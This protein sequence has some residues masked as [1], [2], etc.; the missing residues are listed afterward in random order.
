MSVVAKREH[1][2][3]FNKQN[4][5][6]VLCVRFDCFHRLLSAKCSFEFFKSKNCFLND[7]MMLILWSKNSDR[8]LLHKYCLKSKE[9]TLKMKEIF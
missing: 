9:V 1:F 7:V 5:Q 3:G 8:K 2:L 4:I 6:S